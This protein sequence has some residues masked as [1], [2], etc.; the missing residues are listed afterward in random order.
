VAQHD[1]NGCSKVANDWSEAKNEEPA[2][3]EEKQG[4]I[5]RVRTI[6]DR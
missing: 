6:A 5:F 4:G 1:V 3:S 2:V